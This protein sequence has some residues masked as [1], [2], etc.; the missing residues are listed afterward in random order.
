M[1]KFLLFLILL[2]PIFNIKALT[3]CDDSV[4]PDIPSGY[5][6]DYVIL[7]LGNGNTYLFVGDIYATLSSSYFRIYSNDPNVEFN[8][9]ILSNDSWTYYGHGTSNSKTFISGSYIAASTINILDSSSNVVI[10]AGYNVN[11]EVPSEPIPQ[12]FSLINTIASYINSFVNGLQ[13]NNISIEVTFI[14]LIIFNFLVF[15]ICYIITHLE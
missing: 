4:Y 11:C 10:E 1:K 14:S 6:G 7:V 13:N 8:Y 12:D 9:F 15:V 5:S 2:I 3:L